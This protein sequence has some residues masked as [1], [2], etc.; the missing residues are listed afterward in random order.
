MVAVP[1]VRSSTNRRSA[2]AH[3]ICMR[4]ART[5]PLKY[6]TMDGEITREANTRCLP[7]GAAVAC[8]TPTNLSNYN[9]ETSVQYLAYYPRLFLLRNHRIVFISHDVNPITTII[10]HFQFSLSYRTCTRV[11]NTKLL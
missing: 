2:T 5:T 4:A 1:A 6:T 11:S 8:G 3:D 9:H 10:L 7:P